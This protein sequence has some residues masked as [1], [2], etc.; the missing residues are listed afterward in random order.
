MPDALITPMTWLAYAIIACLAVGCVVA[1]VIGAMIVREVLRI[2]R[3]SLYGLGRI[4][5]SSK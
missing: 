4:T 2:R 5:R 1:L 3:Q